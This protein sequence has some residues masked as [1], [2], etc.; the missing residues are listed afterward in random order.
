MS[1]L[2]TLR[3]LHP[4]T[5]SVPLYWALE[6]LHRH[7]NVFLMMIDS[8]IGDDAC[9]IHIVCSPDDETTVVIEL[10]RTWWGIDGHPFGNFKSP[11]WSRRCARH[12]RDIC[13]SLSDDVSA[14]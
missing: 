4:H 11:H 12:V 5:L 2:W 10:H 9:C 14:H 3:A 6:L 13:L 8:Y 7:Q 1:D